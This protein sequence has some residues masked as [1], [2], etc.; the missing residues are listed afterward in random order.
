MRFQKG[1]SELKNREAEVSRETGQISGKMCDKLVRMSDVGEFLDSQTRT[2][3]SLVE[4]RIG[5]PWGAELGGN[6]DT[7]SM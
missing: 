2:L 3:D 6:E 7:R 4:G 1:N 5:E